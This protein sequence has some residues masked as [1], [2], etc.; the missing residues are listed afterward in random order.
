MIKDIVIDWDGTLVDTLPFLHETFKKTFEYLKRKPLS[1]TTIRRLS[2]QYKNVDLFH[3][4]FGE[5]EFLKAKCFFYTYTIEHHLDKLTPCSGAQEVLEFCKRADIKCHIFS[6]K[7]HQ[8]LKTEVEKLGWSN[9]FEQICGSGL[10]SQDKPTPEACTRFWTS[11]AADKDTTLVIGDGPSDTTSARFW[12]C[13]VAIVT[14]SERYIG[15]KPD[16]KLKNLHE[17]IPLLQSM[18]Y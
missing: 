1:Y 11:C 16:Y 7:R 12:G 6:N 3:S 10:F 9:Y 2:H 15:E 13:P 8:I 4:V 5:D 18:L 17:I 14:T